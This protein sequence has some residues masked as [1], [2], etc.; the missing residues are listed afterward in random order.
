LFNSKIIFVV[1]F[2]KTVNLLLFIMMKKRRNKR[3][4]NSSYEFAQTPNIVLVSG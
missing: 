1:L 3:Q 4:F 2:G